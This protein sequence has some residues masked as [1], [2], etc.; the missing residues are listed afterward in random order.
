MGDIA[1]RTID[2]LDYDSAHAEYNA[3]ANCTSIRTCSVVLFPR[4]HKFVGVFPNSIYSDSEDA[5]IENTDR[6]YAY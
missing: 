6:K 4:R 5:D 2:K 1:T 3:N